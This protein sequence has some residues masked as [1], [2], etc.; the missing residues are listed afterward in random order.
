LAWNTTQFNANVA[1]GTV[2]IT[3][4]VFG[5]DVNS[6]AEDITGRR[7][8]NGT[9]YMFTDPSDSATSVMFT[10]NPDSTTPVLS[11]TITTDDRGVIPPLAG[12]AGASLV[13]VDFGA[14]KIMLTP[15]PNVLVLD[16][17]V[18]V[19]TNTIAG[20]IILRK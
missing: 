9:G 17:G 1:A 10:L 2:P 12:P 11:S 8:P 14:G 18:T 19:P 3:S 5:G 15:W 6:V 7:I 13:W 4:R 16:I 20:T